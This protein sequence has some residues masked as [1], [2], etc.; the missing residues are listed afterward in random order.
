MT[1][2]RVRALLVAGALVIA[3]SATSVVIEADAAP[4][5]TPD[6]GPNVHIF[7]PSTDQAAFQAELNAIAVAQVH[8]EFGTRRDAVLF[9]PGT[10]GSAAHPLVFQVGFYTSVA[11][12]GI[13]PDDVHIKGAIE[14]PNQCNTD[15]CFALTNFWRSLSNLTIDVHTSG[16][17]AL[18]ATAPEDPGCERC[19]RS[20]PPSSARDSARRWRS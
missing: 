17:P 20:R 19:L 3:A 8:N 18:P 6:F 15:G 14:V 10:Y 4:P 12:L 7:K 11:G 5:S 13:S 9:A 16:A 1:L 2:R